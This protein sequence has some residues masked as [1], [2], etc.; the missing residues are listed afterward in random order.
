MALTENRLYR[1]AL[2]ILAIG[3]ALAALIHFTA[4]E[5]RDGIAYE[6]IDGKVYTVPA[7]ESKRYRLELERFGGKA[8]IFA[9]DLSRWFVGLW[10]GKKFAKTVS[11]L[12]IAA[13][14]LVWRLGFGGQ[15]TERIEDREVVCTRKT[16][17][18]PARTT[19]RAS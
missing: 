2:L 11:F 13:S 19:K 12:S 16:V 10:K 8:A 1:V 5:T 6:I 17:G 9:D 4:A 14:L 3:Q 15:K 18:H 7:Y